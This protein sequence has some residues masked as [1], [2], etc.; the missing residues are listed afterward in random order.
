MWVALDPAGNDN[1]AVYYYDRSHRAGVLPHVKSFAPGT[2]QRL[3]DD[4]DLG[5]YEIVV[6]SLQPGDA[7]IHHSEIIHGSQANTSEQS[8]RGWTLQYKAF[9]AEYD[10]VRLARYEAELAEQLANRGQAE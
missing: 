10:S 3:A 2:S 8:R 9:S 5:S 6:P 1:G 4:V 7:L